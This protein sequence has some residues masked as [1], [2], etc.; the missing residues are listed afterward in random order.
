VEARP[1][2][3]K[4]AEYQGKDGQ[5]LPFQGQ[6]T[7]KKGVSGKVDTK[8]AGSPGAEKG[9]GNYCGMVWDRERGLR[10]HQMKN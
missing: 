1:R 4:N 8:E 9:G 6:A 2:F 10:L 3:G 5:R 7:H